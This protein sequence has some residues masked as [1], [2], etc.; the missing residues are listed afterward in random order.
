MKKICIFSTNFICTHSKSE[1]ELAKIISENYD[2]EFIYIKNKKENI[3][4]YKYYFNIFKINFFLSI[5][6]NKFYFKKI[7]SKY[8]LILTR[9]INGFRADDIKRAINEL[10]IKTIIFSINSIGSSFGSGFNPNVYLSPGDFWY[11]LT[12]NNKNYLCGL[13]KYNFP[14]ISEKKNHLNLLCYPFGTIGH[15]G[16]SDEIKE[17]D[18]INKYKLKKK[19]ILF[20][21]E[22]SSKYT[23]ND[24]SEK[25]YLNWTLNLI[26]SLNLDFI[27]EF[28]ILI[29]PHPFQ[30]AKPFFSYSR[31][32][33]NLNK[34]FKNF[35]I[36]KPEDH[37][38]SIKYCE[39][40]IVNNSSVL[41]EVAQNFK[42]SVVIANKESDFYNLNL[43][44]GGFFAPEVCG[45][46]FNN[47]EDFKKYYKKN[48]TIQVNRKNY[49]DYQRKYLKKIEKKEILR[50]IEKV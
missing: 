18:F 43:F 3:F 13:A 8:D 4:K 48:K 17:I 10:K 42:P 46:I 45:E 36:I 38:S 14:F 1:L 33:I 12:K 2:V 50:I 28:E 24:L 6:F 34:Y 35:K 19:Y 39:F 5:I 9:P 41:Y 47:Y 40:A 15:L 20:C 32:Q 23:N 44:K 21:L 22:S 31:K 29:K 11:E 49:H 25:K 26:K 27:D 16:Q 7:F 37:I 30:L